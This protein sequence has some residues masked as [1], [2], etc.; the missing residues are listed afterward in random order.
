[1]QVIWLIA[2]HFGQNNDAT[3]EREK[4]GIAFVQML[5]ISTQTDH[6]KSVS[7]KKIAHE[8][9][10]WNFFGKFGHQ[11]KKKTITRSLTDMKLPRI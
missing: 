7:E 1:M 11:K 3:R 9:H 6:N 2:A 4:T 8:I 5:Q 10:F